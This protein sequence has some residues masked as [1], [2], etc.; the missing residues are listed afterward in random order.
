MQHLFQHLLLLVLSHQPPLKLSNSDSLLLQLLFQLLPLS[1]SASSFHWSSQTQA[2][3]RTELSVSTGST[4]KTTQPT[5]LNRVA[6]G[7]H[8]LKRATPPS[9]F[10]RVLAAPYQSEPNPAH[11]T[12]HNAGGRG[13]AGSH[14]IWTDHRRT[15]NP[16]SIRPFPFIGFLQWQVS[17]QAEENHFSWQQ[18]IKEGNHPLLWWVSNQENQAQGK[19]LVA[20]YRL[21]THVAFCH[22]LVH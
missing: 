16:K 2:A 14:W 13:Q 1:A 18:L 15:T 17:K 20:L 4:V 5:A 7:N 8:V 22:V 10:S 11:Y 6:T 3:S 12:R 19:V 21:H 9:H